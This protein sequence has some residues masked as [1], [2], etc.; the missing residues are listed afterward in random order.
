MP[1]LAVNVTDCVAVM[2]GAVGLTPTF[3]PAG[4]AVIVALA[5]LLWA[6]APP[7]GE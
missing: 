7:A 1:P 6:Y 5:V 2:T 4:A 3:W